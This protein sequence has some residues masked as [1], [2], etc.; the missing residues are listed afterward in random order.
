MAILAVETSSSVCGVALLDAGSGRILY[1]CNRELVRLH[2]KELL[3]MI[4]QAMQEA[5]VPPGAIDAVAVSAG[6]GSFTGI[7]IGFAT[8]KALAWCWDVPVC[9]VGSLDVIASNAPAGT[10]ACPVL[11]ARRGLL[12]SAAFV[13][14]P[15]PGDTEEIHPA[16]AYLAFEIAEQ[17]A[18]QA[19]RLCRKVVLLGD[20]VSLVEAT[21]RQTLLG[22]LD[23]LVQGEWHPRA[24]NLAALSLR[25]FRTGLVSRA[26]DTKPT[27]IRRS[28]AEDKWDRAFGGSARKCGM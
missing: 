2:S 11:D 19:R 1:E 3:P 23:V 5:G 18:A 13:R 20:A 7:R 8:V 22:S 27:Y 12:Y 15:E 21:L 25:K 26:Q 28:E 24:G 16:G 17:T 10:L 14:G 4:D 9:P 6:P